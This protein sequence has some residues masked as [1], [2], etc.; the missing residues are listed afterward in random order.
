MLLVAGYEKQ[1]SLLFTERD[2]KKAARALN[3]AEKKANKGK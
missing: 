1:F 3:K 2:A